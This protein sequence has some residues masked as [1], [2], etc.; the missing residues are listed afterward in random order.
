MPVGD[1]RFSQCDATAGDQTTGVIGRGF[2]GHS[3]TATGPPYRRMP[4]EKP[5]EGVADRQP[6]RIA[7]GQMREFMREQNL[8][9]KLPVS[10]CKAPGQQHGGAQDSECHRT[11]ESGGFTD[12][13]P[14]RI[15]AEVPGE[16]SDNF[17]VHPLALAQQRLQS[18]AG[19]SRAESNRQGPRE[20]HCCEEGGPTRGLG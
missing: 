11:G 14:A 17:Q 12:L 5:Y 16:R 4:P 18:P 3:Q 15:Q 6:E 10:I 9:F 8:Q 1:K 13:N 2:A 19:V 20:P 7:G